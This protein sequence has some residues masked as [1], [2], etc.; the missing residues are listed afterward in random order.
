MFFI[1]KYIK[2]Q[3]KKE[4]KK[5]GQSVREEINAPRQVINAQGYGSAGGILQNEGTRTGSCFGNEA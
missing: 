1:L 2:I 4:K 5:R 3:K